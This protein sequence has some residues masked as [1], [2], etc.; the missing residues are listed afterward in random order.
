MKRTDDLTLAQR[1]LDQCMFATLS[2]SEPDGTPYGIPV[3][4]V[5]DGNCL[6][7]HCAVKGRKLNAMRANP[8]VCLSC[9][10]TAAVRPGEFD[11][12]YQSVVA[13]GTACEVTE[14]EEKIKAL[15]LISEKY[16]H[17][18]MWDFPRVL[19]KYLPHT[20]IW[21]ITLDTITTKG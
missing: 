3:S 8:R 12:D 18:D 2:L 15:R 19:E 17:D 11:I 5:R 9:V 10:G 1:L 14:K 13:F 20:G 21:K 6:Y 4:P 16:C 7:F